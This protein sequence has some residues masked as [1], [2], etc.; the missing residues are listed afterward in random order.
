MRCRSCTAPDASAPRLWVHDRRSTHRVAS[1][2]AVRRNGAR[3]ASPL[4][5]ITNHVAIHDD[6]ARKQRR[7]H[8]RQHRSGKGREENVRS[9]PGWPRKRMELHALFLDR[10][11]LAHLRTKG[12]I[13]A[14]A[15]D[16]CAFAIAHL[17]IA[18]TS[19]CRVR[20]GSCRATMQVQVGSH[21]AS[22]EAQ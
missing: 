14:E 6:H 12:A 19:L 4:G 8:G 11:R 13:Q 16:P 17:A 10:I 18:R 21:P 1:Q 20:T 2:G 22:L 5:C 15:D 3:R 9:A 7:G